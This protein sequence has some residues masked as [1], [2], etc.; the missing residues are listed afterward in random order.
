MLN[1]PFR[2]SEATLSALIL[3]RNRARGV[4]VA[5]WISLL[6]LAAAAQPVRVSVSSSGVQAHQQSIDV[7]ISETGR[8]EFP[9]APTG[10][11]RMSFLTDE[12]ERPPATPPF[13]I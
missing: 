12:R 4:L 10:A 6:P 7:D 11:C 9:V 13:W 2:L 8:F 3:V 1:A 5:S